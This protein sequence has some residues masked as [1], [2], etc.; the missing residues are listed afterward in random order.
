MHSNDPQKP[1]PKP[2]KRPVQD[3]AKFT[4]RVIYDGFVR[5]WQRDGPD[6]VTTRAI[7]NET[8]YAVGTLY[9]YFPNK[10]A[11]LSGY[12]RHT[13]D[14]LIGQLDADQRNCDGL[15]WQDRLARLINLTVG[16]DPNAPY[17]D[18]EM[19]LMEGQ[20][21]T[22]THHQRAYDALSE[23]WLSIITAWPDLAR[24]PPPELVRTIFLTVW[25]ARR[26]RLLIDMDAGC[27][28]GWIE[29]LVQMGEGLLTPFSDGEGS[30][31]KKTGPPEA[32]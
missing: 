24:K 23:T 2:H 5:I 21:A 26:Y 6:A 8:G 22:L 7:A 20:I 10:T 12:V 28:P 30:G 14:T 29:N 9:E 27:P 17:F 4:V 18:R 25:G 32:G 31:P 16:N 11:L 1:V 13:I 19:L 3:R 15:P